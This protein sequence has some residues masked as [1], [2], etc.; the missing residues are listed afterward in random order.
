MMNSIFTT[1]HQVSRRLN[2]HHDTTKKYLIALKIPAYKVGKR[3]YYKTVDIQ[4]LLES[5]PV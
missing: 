2:L 3:T 5:V 1:A 4:P